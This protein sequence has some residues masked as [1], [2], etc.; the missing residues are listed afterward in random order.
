MPNTTFSYEDELPPATPGRVKRLCELDEVRSWLL[1]Q[2]DGGDECLARDSE[3]T[4]HIH[5][6]EWALRKLAVQS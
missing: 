6:V 3:I 2:I 1:D 4:Q 5:S